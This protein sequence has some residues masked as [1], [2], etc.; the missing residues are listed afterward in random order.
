MKVKRVE[1]NRAETQENSYNLDNRL[2]Q[3]SQIKNRGRGE[4]TGSLSGKD[5][6]DTKE[7]A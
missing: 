6:E 1:G 4:G 2:Q 7:S 3:N 5:M